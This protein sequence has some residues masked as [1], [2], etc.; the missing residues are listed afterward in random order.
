MGSTGY[1]KWIM[2][3]IENRSVPYSNQSED[4]NFRIEK[5]KE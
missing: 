5:A 3:S 1:L 2:P 4:F